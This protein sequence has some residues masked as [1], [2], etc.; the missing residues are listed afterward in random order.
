VRGLARACHADRHASR[1][2]EVGR[3]RPEQVQGAEIDQHHSHQ[4]LC[5]LIEG[6]R[7]LHAEADD[8]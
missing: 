7:Q 4:Q 5:H 3:L 6:A 1:A 2:A 8:Q